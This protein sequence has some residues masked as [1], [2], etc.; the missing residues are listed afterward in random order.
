[1]TWYYA[2]NNEQYGPV[3]REE[4]VALV[5]RGMLKAHDLIWSHELGD[6]WVPAGTQ[7]WL[8]F[9]TLLAMP[10]STAGAPSPT[11]T[12]SAPQA[13]GAAPCGM[14]P[15]SRLMERARVSMTGRWTLAAFATGVY[16]V[17][18]LVP[19]IAPFVWGPLALGV[20]Y[21]YLAST[22]PCAGPSIELML[23]GF[24]RFGAAFWAQVLKVFYIFLWSLLLIVPGIVAY[25]AYAM[26]YFIIADN[27]GI[28]AVE[29]IHRSSLLMKGSK[30]KLF[31]LHWRFFGWFLLGILT[32]GVAF[33]WVIPYFRVSL[34]LFY[35]DLPHSQAHPDGTH[36]RPGFA[37]A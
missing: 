36:A 34:A 26:T 20:A 5:Q 15:N 14:T 16:Y 28:S 37:H 27:P 8:T 3:Y 6:R 17:V 25:Y 21:F 30:G 7:A 9:R 35:E 18:L 19:C 32:C 13:V 11:C 22:R 10:V 29:A 4:L 1:M 31:C 23:D 33:L 12:G 24:N 2:V